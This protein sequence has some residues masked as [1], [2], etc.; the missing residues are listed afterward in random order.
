MELFCCRNDYQV[1]LFQICS[2]GTDQKSKM[3]AIAGQSLTL[4]P[5]GNTLE[6]LLGNDYN[7]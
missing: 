1:V 3:A 6:D 7:S 2:F 5:M 4:D